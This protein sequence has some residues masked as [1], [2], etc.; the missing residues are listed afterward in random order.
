MELL[1]WLAFLVAFIVAIVVSHAL[2]LWRC[3]PR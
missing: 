2:G 3:E 1:F